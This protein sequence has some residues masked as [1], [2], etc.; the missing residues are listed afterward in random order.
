MV[1]TVEPGIYFHEHLLKG[2]KGSVWVDHDVLGGLIFLGHL[3]AFMSCVR[4]PLFIMLTSLSAEYIP[5]GGVRIEDVVHITVDG[6]ENLT[7][8][9]SE[10]SWVESVCSGE[11]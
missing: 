4:R 1:V 11:I 8:V 6:Y 9:R 3:W 5:I 7:T 2:V 10:R